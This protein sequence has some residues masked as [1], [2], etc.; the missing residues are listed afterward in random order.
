MSIS[1]DRPAYRILS[2]N[3]F[4]GPDDHLY[5]EGEEIFFDGIP[6][7]EMEPLN[8]FALQRLTEYVEQLDK[9]AKDASEKLGRPF[10]GR[11]RS[12]DGALAFASEVQRNEMSIMGKKRSDEVESVSRVEREDTPETGSTTPKRGRG[13]PRK[14]SLALIAN[15]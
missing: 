8:Q 11:P 15:S 2:P 12:L 5:Q 6:N 7:E 1:N 13:R 9:L 10:I 14:D 3:G 4:F